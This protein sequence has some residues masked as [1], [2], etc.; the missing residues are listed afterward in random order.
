MECEKTGYGVITADKQ[1]L[2]FDAAGNQEIAA[3]LKKSTAKEHLRVDVTGDVDGTTL[4][5]KSLKLL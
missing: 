3:A 2:K 1:Y 5:V 4:H